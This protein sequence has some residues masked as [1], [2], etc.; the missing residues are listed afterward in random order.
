MNIEFHYYALR[1]LCKNAGFPGED[2]STIAIS[3]Q[4]VDEC[5]AP[6]EVSGKGSGLMQGASDFQ[7]SGYS[8]FSWLKTAASKA[9]SA[10]G[11]LRG[12]IPETTY[13]GSLFE[14]WNKAAA[15]H[16]AFCGQLFAQRG[17]E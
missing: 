4:L 16:K 17:I 6:W 10:L 1:Y 11:S 9:Q 2:A 8:R 13:R 14:R 15:D 5:T 12:T 7:Y 3:S